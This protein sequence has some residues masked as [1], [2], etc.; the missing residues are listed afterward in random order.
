MTSAA[1]LA[2]NADGNLVQFGQMQLPPDHE[3]VVA[4]GG[5]YPT[6]FLYLP[7]STKLSRYVERKFVI[8]KE[9]VK[10]AGSERAEMAALTIHHKLDEL[11]QKVLAGNISDPVFTTVTDR[12]RN[13]T[14][15]RVFGLSY[16]V[17]DPM[18]FHALVQH[19]LVYTRFH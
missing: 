12:V 16:E 18:E 8:R 1:L 17:K 15:Y 3:L 13:V 10:V 11:W 7:Y 5:G 6:G 4:R 19:P 9:E 2:R 14:Y